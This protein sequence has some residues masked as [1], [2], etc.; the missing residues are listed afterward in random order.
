MSRLLDW[1]DSPE[2]DFGMRFATDDG[3]WD[4]HDWGEMVGR[5]HDAA[6]KIAADRRERDAPVA[7]ILPNGPDFVSVF[8]GTLAAGNICCPLAPPNLLQDRD[9]YVAHL[10]G[11]VRAADPA[12]IATAPTYLDLVEQAVENA[13]MADRCPVRVLDTEPTSTEFAIEPPAELALLQ[14]TSG[15]SGRPRGARISWSN[16]EGNLDMMKTWLGGGDRYSDQ[17]ATWLPHYH[18]MGLIGAMLTPPVEQGNVWI[19]RPEQFVRRPVRWLECFGRHGATLGASPTFG[20][21]HILRR[22]RP[23]HLDGMDFSGWRAAVAGAERIDAAVLSSFAELLEP[24]GFRP[25]RLMGGYGLAEATLLVAGRT[26][27]TPAPTVRLDWSQLEMGKPVVVTDRAVIGDVDA[28]GDATGWLV[29]CGFAHRGA[30]VIVLD[31]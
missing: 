8:F 26:G 30:S 6:A 13:G 7:I 9:G 31:E 1:L 16:L 22:V 15:S 27:E 21:A 18:D 29:G 17:I 28:V 3:G 25:S 24:F 20:Y 11:L 5:V 14:F 4:F 2:T 12:L 10:C 23:T 19:M